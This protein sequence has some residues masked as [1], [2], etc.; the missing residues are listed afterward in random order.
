MNTTTVNVAANPS[1]TH[2][3]A[4]VAG[5]TTDI[6]QIGT[7]SIDAAAGV[8]NP[9]SGLQVTYAQ[10]VA[11]GTA[12][13]LNGDFSA[14]ASPSDGTKGVF[15]GADGGNCGVAGMA[16]TPA[17]PTTAA[18]FATGVTPA[19]AKPLCFSVTAANAVKVAAQT[20]TVQA[21]ITPAAGSTAANLTPIDAGKFI[22]NGLVL[23]AAFAETTGVSG[24]SR[25]VSLSNTS[26]VDAPY[27]VRCL[28]NSVAVAGVAGTVPAN[29]STR[30]S[31][32]TPGLGCPTN[33][34]MRG[35]EITFAVTPGSVI[36]SMVSQSL[37]TGQASYDAM[38]GNQ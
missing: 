7:V 13:V 3:I 9:A 36:G 31:L 11:A 33:G 38:T 26:S 35:I 29:S 2:F 8:L 23:K 28:V 1:Y 16:P 21:N 17:T 14:A 19:A 24:V 37:S 22:R 12:L 18:S 10:L 27:T 30:Q 20:F 34:T 4:G 6:A 15:L 5:T 25:S 32:G